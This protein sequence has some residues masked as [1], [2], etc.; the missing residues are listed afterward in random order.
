V[1][2]TRITLSPMAYRGPSVLT[3]GFGAAVGMWA[4]GY[5]SRLPGVMLPSPLL[6]GLVLSCLLVGGWVLG[7]YAGLG[8]RYGAL[9]GLLTGS[10]N[11]LVLGSFLVGDRQAA[12]L[13]SALLWLPGS[14]LIAVGLAAAGALVGRQWFRREQPFVEWSAAFVRVA[15]VAVMLL[16][17]VG[18]LVTSTGAGLAVVDWP[19]S[20]GY[21]MFLYP[22]SRMTGGIYYEHAHRLFGAL[23]GLTTLVLA[24]HLQLR[25]PRPWVRRLGWSVLAMVVIQGLMGGLRVT[26]AL[27]LSTSPDAMRPSIALAMIHGVF[28]QLVFGTLVALGAFT[29]A[30]WRGNAAPTRRRSARVDHVLAWLLVAL[31]FAQLILGAAQRHLSMLLMVHI[32]FG[33]AVVAP[34]ALHVGFRA[35]GMNGTQRPLQRVGLGLA[36]AVAL[37][38]ALGLAAFVATR[39]GLSPASEVLLTTAHQGFGAVLLALAVMLLCWSH[40]LLSPHPVE[41]GPGP[42]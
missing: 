26:G 6:L 15:I 18:G 25:E 39:G 10:I 29:S 8:W 2:A 33:V 7:R 37:Q 34:A 38:I 41:P 19:N 30:T 27:T 36:V 32:A 11:L 4:V 35:W 22:F 14:V 31:L 40:R 42:A 17:V 12:E 28:G 20:F 9:A 1:E 24:V 21:N 23:V 5:V 13:P 3:V 16:L